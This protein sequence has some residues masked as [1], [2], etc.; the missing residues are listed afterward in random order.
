MS[1]IG[2]K[3]IQIPDQVEVKIE[4]DLVM[5]KGPKGE[6]KQKLVPELK[7]EQKDKEVLVKVAN[8]QEKKQ[9]ALWGTFRQLINNMILG[10][11]EGF[12][13]QLEING[14]GYRAEVKG[15]ILVL[16]VGFSHPVNFKIPVGIQVKVEKNII[17]ISGQDKHLVGEIAAQI[18]RIKKPEPYKGKGI[19]YVNEVIRRKAG[20]QAKGVGAK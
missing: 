18:R 3:P 5:V 8:E 1:R 9:R 10:V 12:E 15:E 7:L 13:K 4:G 16:N 19:K 6:L 14:V 2:K 17:T 11:T 20:K